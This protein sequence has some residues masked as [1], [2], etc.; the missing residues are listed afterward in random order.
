MRRSAGDV[1]A[2]LEAWRA[3]GA[4][5]RDPLRFHFIRAL[6]A[7]ADAHEGQA[8]QRLDER[9]SQLVDA[10]ARELAE[11]PAAAA[12]VEDAVPSPAAQRSTLG[13]LLDRFANR[14]DAAAASMPDTTQPP[15]A[16][17][18]QTLPALDEFRRLWTGIRAESQLRES[19]E[20]APADA[21]PLNSGVLVLR[22]LDLM[23]TLSPGYLQHFLSYADA[24]S[25]LEHAFGDTAPA[26]RGTGVAAAGGKARA[27]PR[28]RRGA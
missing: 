12:S 20:Q 15:P 19:L 1:R 17:A 23:R 26:G 10:Y 28:K 22:A 13:L 21:G 6:A 5:R 11:A 24:L 8:R 14:T 16:A 18:F 3:E 27:R 2:M 25:G 7:R 9:L 4:D